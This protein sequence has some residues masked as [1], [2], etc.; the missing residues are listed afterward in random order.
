MLHQSGGGPGFTATM[1]GMIGMKSL[2]SFQQDPRL[3]F[4]FRAAASLLACAGM[5]ADQ[6]DDRGGNILAC[7]FA[8]YKE[9]QEGA[10]THMPKAGFRYV[11][12]NV[13]KPEEV[14]AI[15]KRLAENGL[16]VAVVRGEADLSRESSIDE[17][18]AQLE[19]CRKLGAKFMFLSP[20]HKTVS[21]EVAI[22]RLKK[23]GDAARRHGVTI[24]LETHPD[25]G[26]NGDVHVETMK[27]INHPNIRVN[28]DTGNIT[29]YNRGADAVSELK[30]CIDYVAM[31][32]FKDHNGEF[33]IWNFPAIGDGVVDFPAVMKVLRKHGYTGPV[34]LEIEGVEGVE[35]DGAR[36]K[37]YIERSA[38]TVR[39]LGGFECGG[40]GTGS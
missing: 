29:Y 7:R 10:W 33:G 15:K 27:R 21:G 9:F 12:M 37:K 22:Q 35:M 32:E 39:S 11:F 28:F 23:V 24:G 38:A 40:Q 19:T 36:I 25:L 4:L 18:S 17:L 3:S 31:V 8:N 16:A 26:T 34:T 5:A 30:K 2:L 20:K 14:D 6:G 1:K 13:P